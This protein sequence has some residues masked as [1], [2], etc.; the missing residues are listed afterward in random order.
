M[1]WAHRHRLQEGTDTNVSQ[2]QHPVGTSGCS[3]ARAA[4][5]VASGPPP[6]RQTTDTSS[7]W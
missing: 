1:G 5:G 7:C 2:L 6:S 3:S 4:K